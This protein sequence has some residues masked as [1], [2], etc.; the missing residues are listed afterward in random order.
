[1]NLEKKFLKAQS[2]FFL[3]EKN[4]KVVVA[5][6]GGS[7]SVVLTY[8]LIK[9]KNYLHIKEIILAHVNHM[10]RG[11]ESDEDEKFCVDFA[12]KN[13]LKIE[14]LRVD[15]KSI[16]EK[17]KKSIEDTARQI[18]YEFFKQVKNK[19]KADKIATG[20]HLSDLAETMIMWF[21]QGNR[22]GMKGFSPKEGYIVRPLFYALKEEIKQYA[23]KN[24][25]EY[26][27][28]TSNYMLSYLR[29]IVR[30]KVIPHI[31]SINPS[32]EKS[33]MNLSFLLKYDDTFL[34]NE[35]EKLFSLYK[36]KDYLETKEV[37]EAVL[38]RLIQKW[39]YY[40]AKIYLSYSTV[41]DILGVL[42]KG[43]SKIYHISEKYI[44]LKEYDKLFIKSIPDSEKNEFQYKLKLGQ[45]LHIKEVGMT[46][47][48]YLADKEKLN[49]LK[50]EKRIVCFDIPDFSAD[51]EFIIR[52]RKKGDKFL[53]F[54]KKTE[55]KLKD[56]FIELKIPKNMRD[57]IP[58]LVFRNK[59]LW[60][61]GYKRSG[62]FPVSEKSTKLVCFEIKGG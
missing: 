22:K 13:N 30:L 60:I 51:E 37:P 26:R 21:I 2:D 35:A 12:K 59:I 14:I 8:L 18:R 20:H 32:L 61:I 55:K 5:F 6:S 43:G 38:Y 11:K 49:N 46:I 57:S 23:E 41:I 28:D 39:V 45:S 40:K 10:L 62:Y 58:L 52:N 56:I 53:P 4:D 25:I 16:A 33:L 7:D 24:K 3:F 34:E 27:I 9:L 17:E 47:S 54:G 15:I 19:Y 36:D 1:M 31:K 48:S 29:N 42:K 50:D 44:L